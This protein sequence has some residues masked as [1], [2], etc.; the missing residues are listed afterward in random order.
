MQVVE[1]VLQLHSFYSFSS[2]SPPV[3]WIKLQLI[4][5]RIPHTAAIQRYAM[6]NWAVKS[7]CGTA[8]EPAPTSRYPASLRLLEVMI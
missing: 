3:L 4:R 1:N 5:V 6:G 8:A 2:R 7:E